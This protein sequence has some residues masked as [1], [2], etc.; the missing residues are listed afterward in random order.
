MKKKSQYNRKIHATDRDR[1][2]LSYIGKYG[3]ANAKQI[4]EVVFSKRT[5]G[6]AKDRLSQLVS[7]GY[8]HSEVTDARGKRE[9]IYWIERK[10]LMELEERETAQR[11]RPPEK[12]IAHTLGMV[13]VCNA[14]EKHHKIESFTHEHALKS[15]K[16]REMLSFTDNSEMQI[17]DG[18]ISIAPNND[19]YLRGGEYMIEIDGDYWGKKLSHKIQ[20][21]KASNMRVLYVCFTDARYGYVQ[22]RAGA[23]NIRVV[24]YSEL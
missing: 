5:L 17:G 8:L 4:H 13:D 9:R 11:G 22:S 20:S 7:G 1:E 12:E 10:G 6:R 16:I 23:E 2:I 18:L 24:H 15:L 3:C 21:L 19:G 14:I